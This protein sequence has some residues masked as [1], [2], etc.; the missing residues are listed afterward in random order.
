M[1]PFTND[2]GKMK[3]SDAMPL[4]GIIA[5]DWNLN[6][7]TSAPNGRMICMGNSFKVATRILRNSARNN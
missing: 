1:Y 5:S 4:L 3:V 6:M 7:K 2:I